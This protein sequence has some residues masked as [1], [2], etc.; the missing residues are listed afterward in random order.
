MRDHTQI[1][2]FCSHGVQYAS[3]WST[4][5]HHTLTGY[6]LSTPGISRGRTWL[7]IKTS[8]ASVA[9]CTSPSPCLSFVVLLS[10]CYLIVCFV[11]CDISQSLCSSVISDCKYWTGFMFY[12]FKLG[13][14]WLHSAQMGEGKITLSSPHTTGG[15]A[16]IIFRIVKHDLAELCHCDHSGQECEYD[17]VKSMLLQVYLL[18][19][20]KMHWLIV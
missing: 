14:P 16:K 5:A 9:L 1:S 3:R 2:Q 4:P 20:Q 7:R 18:G 8:M 12:D 6:W 17:N 10:A 13:Q 19:C 15:S 11:L